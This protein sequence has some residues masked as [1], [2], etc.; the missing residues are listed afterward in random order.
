MPV[1]PAL[2]ALDVPTRG[3]GV[4]GR[5]VTTPRAE[6]PSR[7]VADFVTDDATSWRS[8]SRTRSSANLFIAEALDHLG[9]IEAELLELDER[10][11]D[12]EPPQRHLPP[13]PHRQGQRVGARHRVGGARR[14]QGRE[15]A[16]SRALRQASRWARPKWISCSGRGR[17][18]ADD[19]RRR[20]AAG[21][22]AA[23]GHRCRG[24]EPGAGGR[25]P[26]CG[27][28]RGRRLRPRRR[29]ALDDRRAAPSAER[30]PARPTSRRSSTIGAAQ[31]RRAAATTCRCW[32]PPPPP[33][34]SIRGSSTTSW[35]WS[36]S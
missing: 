32:R 7:D 28:A 2:D 20:P 27:T 13:L 21:G 16:R 17:A 22:P 18:V 34:R 3:A 24:R 6:A 19:Q 23:Q 11:E 26:D 10:P 12:T 35:T 31:R 8:C 36:A 4:D 9:T 15:P 14:A 29:L 30:R 1:E 25:A 33:S 5:S